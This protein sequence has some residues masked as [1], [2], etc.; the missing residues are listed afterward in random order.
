MHAAQEGSAQG[1]ADAAALQ[2]EVA[3]LR[4]TNQDL[5]RELRAL[6]AQQGAGAIS[7]GAGALHPRFES[8][9]GTQ[10][11]G[12]HGLASHT[13]IILTDGSG[14]SHLPPWKQQWYTTGEGCM[15]WHL[16]L[17]II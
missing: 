17:H 11:V 2:Q 5:E 13:T 6:Q 1:Q 7:D 9:N 15:A 12:V 16:T 10:Q 14:V 3:V 4:Q 8:S